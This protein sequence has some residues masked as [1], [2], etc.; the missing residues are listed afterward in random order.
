MANVSAKN[1]SA[2]TSESL[3]SNPT[4]RKALV[5]G[6][7]GALGG[8]LLGSQIDDN[9]R[10][11]NTLVGALTGGVTGA[12]IGALGGDSSN[13]EAPISKKNN[14]WLSNTMSA[15]VGVGGT[16]GAMALLRRNPAFKQKLLDI[17]THRISIGAA[18]IG[19]GWATSK[20]FSKTPKE[21]FSNKTTEKF[22]NVLSAGIKGLL[23]GGGLGGLTGGGLGYLEQE[24]A[25]RSPKEQRRNIIR[26]ALTG[27]AIGGLG[28]GSASA[29]SSLLRK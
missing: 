9:N 15:G 4:L 22:A 11:R 25:F 6:G 13:I 7:I 10:V 24:N 8:G 27:A 29:L 14:N 12:G 3:L 28:L 20:L 19:S 26:K 23:V 1:K 5:G 18:G 16:V 21:A 2:S 17:A